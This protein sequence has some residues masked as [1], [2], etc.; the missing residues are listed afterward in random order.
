DDIYRLVRFLG[1]PVNKDAVSRIAAEVDAS[2]TGSVSF[3]EFLKVVRFV[4]D[5]EFENII[6]VFKRYCKDEA[7]EKLHMDK[8]K[9]A[10]SDMQYYV[11]DDVKTNILETMDDLHDDDHFIKEE[12]AE[13]LR[14]YR[15][16]NG[17]TEE[18]AA[19]IKE[20]FD[21]QCRFVNEKR[22]FAIHQD[23]VQDGTEI[24]SPRS[25]KHQTPSAERRTSLM[26]RRTSQVNLLN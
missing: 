6:R 26:G 18:S 9:I 21:A 12:V 11:T 1:F 23:A 8:F 4:R 3:Q 15:R 13:F 22:A 2:G 14:E 20:G 25:P 19:E 7:R 10:L 24:G 17:F 5:H 16:C